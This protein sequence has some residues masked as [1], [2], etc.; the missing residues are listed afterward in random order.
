MTTP[1][2]VVG[3]DGSDQAL[4]AAAWA[5]AEAEL[6]HAQV[7]VVL[8]NNDPARDE[9]LWASIEDV[10]DRLATEHPNVG[11][12]SEIARGHP[13]GELVRRS[14][15]AQLIVVGSRGRSAWSGSLLGSVSTKVATHAHCPVVVVRDH[16]L[17]GPVVVGLDNSS[18]SRAALRF[19]FDEAAAHET[20]LVAMQVWRDTR[21][22]PV[23]PPLDEEV[24]ELRDE[25]RRGLAEQLAGWN[26]EY[27]DVGVREIARRGNPVTELTDAAR[28]AQLLVV[29]HQ[30]SGG[31]SGLLLGSVATGVLYHAHC[32]VAVVR[33]ATPSRQH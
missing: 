6:R 24:T 16:L 9:E 32:P 5:V 22:G 8:V 18:H 2:V 12:C 13:A 15:D 14:A 21:H 23:V 1:D 28:D 30:G 10:V 19:A 7:R 4:T 33:G 3:V 29:G 26:E 11:V 27:P 31:F 25:A 20:D 17:S